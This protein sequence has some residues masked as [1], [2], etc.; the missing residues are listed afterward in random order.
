MRKKRASARDIPI[1]SRLSNLYLIGQASFFFT[2][3]HYPRLLSHLFSRVLAFSSN[4][5]L[6][7][8]T[9]N[10]L[11]SS[12]N[13]FCFIFLSC[14]LFIALLCFSSSLPFVTQIRGHIAGI[15]PPPTTARAFI[16]IAR[17]VQHSFSSVVDSRRAYT[18]AVLLGATSI[19]YVLN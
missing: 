14:R 2:S 18:H 1:P 6:A 12:L 3:F 4:C 5:V 16:F 10:N 7:F 13:L 9:I 17:R 11:M 19:C 8:S 15:S